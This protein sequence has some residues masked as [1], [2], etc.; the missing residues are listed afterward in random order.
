MQLHTFIKGAVFAVSIVGIAF[1][2]LLGL[3]QLGTHHDASPVLIAVHA[4]E[5]RIM[6]MTPS[7]A[8][9]ESLVFGDQQTGPPVRLFIPKINVEATVLS[10]GLTP[11]GV[12]DV[13]TTPDDVA[14]FEQGPRPGER[15]SAV[16][17]GHFGWKNG[18][19]AVFDDL[20]RLS[21]GDKIFLED[22][23]GVRR[24]FAVRELRKLKEHDD[25]STVFSSSDGGTHLNLITCSGV[26]NKNKKSYSDRLVVFTDKVDE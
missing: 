26:W 25:A 20:Y 11:T 6:Q 14:W 2:S 3:S 24:T 23:A 12:M 15:G 7:A 8:V 1:V 5:E 10:L 18:Q 21:E 17:S 22:A 9:I 19:A 4:K 16:I 13:P